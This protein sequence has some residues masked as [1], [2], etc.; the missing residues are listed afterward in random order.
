[1][2]VMALFLISDL[3]VV[4]YCDLNANA[5]SKAV[6]AKRKSKKGMPFLRVESVLR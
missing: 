2:T 3:F 1:M 4:R 6:K 5:G